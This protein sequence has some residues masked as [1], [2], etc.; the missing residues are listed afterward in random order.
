LLTPSSTPIAGAEG[1]P[2]SRHREVPSSLRSLN[3]GGSNAPDPAH[4]AEGFP[5]VVAS[6][7]G[8][9]AHAGRPDQGGPLACR[10]AC[11]LDGRLDESAAHD[12]LGHARSV[13]GAG[14]TA[15][16]RRPFL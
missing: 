13:G 16:G 6:R 1:W 9:P 11:L 3:R 4:A 14:R 7:G 5:T 8:H 12:G 15:R 10:L 2:H